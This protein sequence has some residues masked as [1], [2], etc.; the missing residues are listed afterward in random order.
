MK[1]IKFAIA[2][3]TLC[4]LMFGCA[5]FYKTTIIATKTVDT[6]MTTWAAY[7][8][9]GATTPS[10]DAR[11]IRA[12]DSYRAAC[13]D[14]ASLLEVHKR[15]GEKVTVMSVIEG[16]GVIARGATVVRLISGAQVASPVDESVTID[17]AIRA[18][19][20]ASQKTAAE[21]LQAGK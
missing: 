10:N 2:I 16:A 17:D 19:R 20:S 9:S 5:T 11:V 18:L 4:V 8:A 12:H 21:Y 13:G 15:N 3:S 7:V 1:S 14:A 6:A